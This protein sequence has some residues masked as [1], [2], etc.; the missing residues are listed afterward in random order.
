MAVADVGNVSQIADST[1][2]SPAEIQRPP[3]AHI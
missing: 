1:G 2:L 3:L